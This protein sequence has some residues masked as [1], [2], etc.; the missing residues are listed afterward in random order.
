MV[1]KDGPSYDLMGTV[2]SK[3]Q[4]SVSA[5]MIKKGAEFNGTHTDNR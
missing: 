4:K 5:Y 2:V 1:L 3:C